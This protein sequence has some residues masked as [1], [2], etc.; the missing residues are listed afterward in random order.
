MF[1]VLK[2][3]I[4]T[5]PHAPAPSIGEGLKSHGVSTSVIIY[6]LLY[7]YTIL[8]YSYFLTSIHILFPKD[9]L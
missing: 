8:L 1:T 3:I 6:I 9:N 4:G 7:L 2:D 5:T